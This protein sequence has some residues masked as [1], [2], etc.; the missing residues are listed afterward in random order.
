MLSRGRKKRGEFTKGN[1]GNEE[2]EGDPVW[3]VW[4]REPV[5]T[6]VKSSVFVRPI[7]EVIREGA[8]MNREERALINIEGYDGVDS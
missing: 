5:R 6:S 4:K 3:G 1:Q 8:G 2:A 7:R